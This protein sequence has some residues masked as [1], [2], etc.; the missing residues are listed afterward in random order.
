MEYSTLVNII[1]LIEEKNLFKRN[2]ILK[3][4][5]CKII[6]ENT[7]PQSKKIIF[8]WIVSKWGGINVKDI[9][10]IYESV[11]TFQQ[12]KLK[13]NQLSFQGIASISKILSFM[14][15]K[16]YIIYDARVAYAINWILLKTKSSKIF[17][18]IPESR[19][20]KLNAINVSTLIRTSNAKPYI[21]NIGNSK[22]ISKCDKNLFIDKSKTYVTLCD[23]ISQINM[24]LWDD[25]KKQYPFYTEM[26]L[27]LLAD[28]KIFSDILNSC[29]LT[30]TR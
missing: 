10:K 1:R 20:S 4:I 14:F 6:D 22:I 7:L 29:S 26:L 13:T 18:P 2:I 12:Q 25:D 11:I 24:N 15:P 17:F 27:F 8:K 28:T 23:L 30:I 21:D 19:N 9:D 5:M 3:E 16:E